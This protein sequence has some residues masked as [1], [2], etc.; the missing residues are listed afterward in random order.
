[1][2][3]SMD[4]RKRVIQALEEGMTQYEVSERYK[5]SVSAVQDWVK[6]N[7]EYGSPE[8]Q[9]RSNESYDLVRGIP[10]RRLGEFKEYVLANP[11][12]TNQE[13]GDHFGVSDSSIERYLKKVKITRKKRL[14]AIKSVV[15]KK[16][17]NGKSKPRK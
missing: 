6:L 7:R 2:S 10:D 9:T 5:V 15:K 3:Y 14:M 11:E 12:L 1:M 8:K 13:I 17:K 4:L 16:E